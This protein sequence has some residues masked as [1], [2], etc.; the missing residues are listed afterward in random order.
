MRNL[1][2]EKFKSFSVIWLKANASYNPDMWGEAHWKDCYAVYGSFQPHNP[3]NYDPF[4]YR[5]FRAFRS[6]S[7][8]N[9]RNLPQ[10]F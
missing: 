4:I 10:W 5:W 2:L 6:Y 7:A 8:E 3:E 9:K 1:T